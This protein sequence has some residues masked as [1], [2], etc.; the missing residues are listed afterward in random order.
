MSTETWAVLSNKIMAWLIF[1]IF[2]GMP[3]MKRVN[4]FGNQVRGCFNKH[5]YCDTHGCS[6]SV[7]FFIELE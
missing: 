5:V 4:S 6:F 1:S 7:V 3:L 2:A